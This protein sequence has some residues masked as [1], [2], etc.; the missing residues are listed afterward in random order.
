M[1]DARSGRPPNTLSCCCPLRISLSGWKRPRVCLS[2]ALR[3]SVS[4][5]GPSRR[6]IEDRPACGLGRHVRSR[7]SLEIPGRLANACVVNLCRASRG[8]RWNLA[9]GGNIR[10]VASPSRLSAKCRPAPK[11]QSAS[12]LQ[13]RRTDGYDLRKRPWTTTGTVDTTS[14][15]ARA[16]DPRSTL[17]PSWRGRA[18]DP[19][20]LDRW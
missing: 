3:G 13:R 10:T 2:P 12:G 18:R 11:A 17:Y 14:E 9:R 6:D 16:L 7:A 15:A 4:G 5:R 20:D 19:A 8:N 1:A